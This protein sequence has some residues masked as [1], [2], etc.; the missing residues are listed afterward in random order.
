MSQ[1]KVIQPTISV[2]IITYNQSAF[3]AQAIESVLMQKHNFEWEILIGDDCSSDETPQII[4]RYA[5]KY[6]ELIKIFLHKE[7]LGYVKNT[8][9]LLMAANGKYVA[10]LDG[11][12]YW[13]DPLKLQKQV[14]FLEA[15]H[16][17]SI[18]FHNVKV[19]QGTNEA[20]FTLLNSDIQK[21]ITTIEDICR[22]NYIHPASCTYR[23]YL[24]KKLPVWYYNECPINEWPIYILLAEHGKIK[25]INEV[26]AIYRRHEGAYN[27]RHNMVYKVKD[28]IT[29]VHLANKHLNYKFDKIF[30][31]A[32]IRCY[33]TILDEY[34]GRSFFFRLYYTI[35]LFRLLRKYNNYNIPSIT[36]L[37]K[38][39][40]K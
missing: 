17:F 36:L 10:S 28:V 32:L 37:K 26:M 39:F 1:D 27:S 3:I 4:Q 40:N 20:N 34:I 6:P 35:I 30:T 16:D 2:Y 24:I 18:C 33:S 14:D 38:L 8:A 21:E 19:I 9:G 15:N 25:Y 29:V 31:Q 5:D 13:I 11:D 7:N 22:I 23:N 12:D